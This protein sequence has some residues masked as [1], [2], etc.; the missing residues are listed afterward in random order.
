MT[1]SFEDERQVSLVKH[2]SHSPK[3]RAHCHPS[4]CKKRIGLCAL[5]S[6]RPKAI[7]SVLNKAYPAWNLC[8]LL[9]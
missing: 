3:I 8:L 1:V 4:R 5:S 9:S 2:S 6:Q 7:S